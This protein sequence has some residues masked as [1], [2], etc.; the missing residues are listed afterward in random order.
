VTAVG[1]EP[2]SAWHQR[3][4]E[5]GSGPLLE[6]LAV[7][8]PVQA[9]RLDG[10]W[11]SEQ[12]RGG[13]LV[14]VLGA[15]EPPDVPVLRRMQHHAGTALGLVLDVEAWVG[16]RGQGG[17]PRSVLVSQGWRAAS[18]RPDD[19]LEQVWQELGSAAARGSGSPGPAAGEQAAAPEV[20][21]P[22]P[23]GPEVLR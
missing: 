2:G 23:A 9:P 8:Q 5:V 13:L 7:L 6:T 22:A 19:R 21:G 16:G 17:G 20:L 14:A 12:G 3:D 15:V 4:T 1:E 11:L 10:S 18:L